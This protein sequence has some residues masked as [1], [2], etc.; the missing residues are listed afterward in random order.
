MKKSVTLTQKEVSKI[1]ADYVMENYLTDAFEVN[2]FCNIHHSHFGH[3][4]TMTV[5]ER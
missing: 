4:I 5:E 3:E 1:I 2:V